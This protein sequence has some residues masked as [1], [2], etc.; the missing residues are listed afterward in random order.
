MLNK[1]KAA[2]DPLILVDACTIRHGVVK[3]TRQLVESSGLPV[4]STPM[5]KS[6]IDE[7]YK[8][9]GGVYVGSVSE[10]ELKKRVEEADLLISIGAL[11]SDFNTG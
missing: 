4:Y 2:K 5:G 11:K 1:I 9:F 8:Q 3:E 10:P 7:G 6:A